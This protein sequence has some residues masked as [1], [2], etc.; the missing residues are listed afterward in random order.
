MQIRQ[1]NESYIVERVVLAEW[2]TNKK[3]I[4]WLMLKKTTLWKMQ[5]ERVLTIM[6][7]Y[8]EIEL[9]GKQ[10]NITVNGNENRTA[11]ES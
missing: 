8:Y 5:I 3:V 2:K 6:H 9:A 1:H 4:T 7:R 10:E 11:K